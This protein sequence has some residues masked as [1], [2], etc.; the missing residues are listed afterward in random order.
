MEKTSRDRLKQLARCYAAAGTKDGFVNAMNLLRHF[1]Y[2]SLAIERL[3]L[4]AVKDTVG[5]GYFAIADGGNLLVNNTDI[6]HWGAT[7]EDVHGYCDTLL[8]ALGH[9]EPID[10]A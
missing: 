6:S 1:G 5:K 10:D 3:Y 9:D 4:Q 8:A 2:E 7:D